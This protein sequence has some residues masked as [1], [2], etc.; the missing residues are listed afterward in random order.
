MR[1]LLLSNKSPWPPKDGGSSATL[2]LIKGLSESGAEIT[3]LAINTSRHHTSIEDI[4][5]MPGSKVDL[6]LVSLNTGFRP[7]KLVLNLLFSSKPFNIYRFYSRKVSNKLLEILRNQYDV[8]QIEGLAMTTYLGEIEKVHGSKIVF[9]PHNVEN[10]IWYDLSSE[11]GNVFYRLYFRKIASRLEKYE[12]AIINRFDAVVPITR[13]DH[14]WFKE[15]GLT[16]PSK[17]I[18]SGIFNIHSEAV[19]PDNLSVFFIGALDWLPNIYGLKWLVTKV[20]PLIAA[21]ETGATLHIAGRNCSK[22]TARHFS[23]DRIIF[24]GEVESSASFIRKYSV[25]VVPLFSGSGLRIKIIEGMSLGRSIVA[26]PVAAEGII[27][28]S[29]KDLFI[30]SEPGEFAGRVLTLLKDKKLRHDTGRNAI[31]NVIKNY[32]ILAEAR[33]LLKFYSKQ[34]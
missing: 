27:C 30:A 13:T 23:A 26:T 21:E 5:D 32:N 17:I 1:I 14:N 33:S 29:G 25:M 12:K 22:L 4:A 11:T 28:D 19:S 34:T 31:E 16:S 20:W 18:P 9:R 8:I 2:G 7:V 3:V 15:A 10:K 24:H 6:H